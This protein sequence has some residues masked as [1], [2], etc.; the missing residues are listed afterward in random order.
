MK[1]LYTILAIAAVAAVACSKVERN[2]AP[3]T[4][5]GFQVANYLSQ[6]KADSH[7]HTSFIDELA[8]LGINSDQYFKSKAFIHAAQ[9]DGTVAAPAPFFVAGTGSI[10]SINY[11]GSSTWKPAHPYYWPKSPLS[12]ISFFS[13]YDYQDQVTPTISG[14]ATDGASVTLAWADRTIAL[15]DNV[16]Y[17]DAAYHYKKNDNGAANH[18]LD[19][20]TEGVPTLFHHALAKVRFTIAQNPMKEQDGSSDNYTFWDVTLSNVSLS[21]GSIKNNGQLSL[22]ET[23]KTTASTQ[24]SWTLP[25]PAI[26]AAPTASQTYLT[27][28]LGNTTGAIFDTD[29]ARGVDSSSNPVLLT[30]A[31]QDLSGENF[32]A[33]NFFAVLPQ[34]IGNGVTLTFK[35]TIK[36][37]YGTQ[38]QYDS[39]KAAILVS[40]ETINVNDYGPTVSGA[41]YGAPYTDNG[42]QL[43]AI[44][45]AWAN[46]LMNH[47][48][49]YNI[50][51]NPKTELILYD[52]AVE[53][54][55]DEDSVDQTVPEA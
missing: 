25:S 19:G 36:Q 52:P 37:Y 10:E 53:D 34:A 15:K 42:I 21:S 11:D 50:I 28:N 39:N 17:A 24:G 3:E 23:S 8:E 43:N 51:I 18:K 6:T 40:S 14:Y 5:I 1:K 29:V 30:A 22:S 31:A 55:A 44:T 16:M 47:Q 7:D 54:W 49:V 20:V 9:E 26:W 4:L 32:M 45:G 38:A 46:W 13:W 35:Y 48:Y 33:N 41:T 27:S 2:D 12:S